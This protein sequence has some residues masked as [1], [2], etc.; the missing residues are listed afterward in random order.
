MLPDVIDGLQSD[1]TEIQLPGRTFRLDFK[2]NTIKGFLDGKEAV[3]QAIILILSTERIEKEIYSWNYGVEINRLI[4]KP[5]VL[6][7][8]R[9]ANTIT[10]AL[11]QDD[12]ITAV[13]DFRFSTD[14]NQAYASFTAE[15]SE[16]DIE[17]GWYFDV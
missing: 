9:L 3:K 12:R 7:Q 16:G 14:K 4:G 2:T 15:T 6:V 13:R 8:A 11:L 10:D 1:F 17:T 5:P